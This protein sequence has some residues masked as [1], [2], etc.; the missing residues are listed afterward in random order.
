MGT[1][2]STEEG[3]SRCLRQ[4]GEGHRLCSDRTGSASFPAA[5]STRTPSLFSWHRK[6]YS[7]SEFCKHPGR[8]QNGAFAGALILW[9]TVTKK[10][11]RIQLRYSPGRSGYRDLLLVPGPL[12]TSRLLSSKISHCPSVRAKWD[13]SSQ[14]GCWLGN[15]STAPQGLTEIPYSGTFYLLDWQNCQKVGFNGAFFFKFVRGLHCLPELLL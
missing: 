5:Q 8:T 10:P 3:G 11:K 6:N 14:G 1:F 7:A 15:S 9:A 13:L 4:A 12:P 2:W